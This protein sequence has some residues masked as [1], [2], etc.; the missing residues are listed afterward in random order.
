MVLRL[1]TVFTYLK[2]F[3]MFYDHEIAVRR[4]KKPEFFTVLLVFLPESGG[5]RSIPGIP[6]NR[7]LAVVPAKIGISV[8]RNSGGFW[9]GHGITRTESTGTESAEFFFQ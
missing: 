2:S 3:S 6:R 7:I 5:I 8:P 1:S 4:V 9:N